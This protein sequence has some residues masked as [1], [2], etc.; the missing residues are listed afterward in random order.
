MDKVVSL[1]EYREILTR[2]PKR[3]LVGEGC[4]SDRSEER[5]SNLLQQVALKLGFS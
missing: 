3:A 1:A 4:E 5:P 2:G